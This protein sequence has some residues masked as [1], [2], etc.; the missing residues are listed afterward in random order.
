MKKILFVAFVGVLLAAC[1]PEPTVFPVSASQPSVLRVG[2]V[3]ITFEVTSSTKRVTVVNRND[4]RVGVL[5]KKTDNM[6]I[7]FSD[8]L[9]GR[10]KTEA[11]D[12]VFFE[13][14]WE[15]EITVIVYK[16]AAEVADS[17]LEGLTA[18]FPDEVMDVWVFAEIRDVIMLQF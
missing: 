6:A 14:G 11:A 7:V 4:R 8:K 15:L 13:S 5:I 10:G 1:G 9:I 18:N 17:L 12:S 16:D 3:E 2:G